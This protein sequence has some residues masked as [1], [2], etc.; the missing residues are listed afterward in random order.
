MRTMMENFAPVH[1][2]IQAQLDI[3]VAG[4]IIKV[5]ISKDYKN[6]TYCYKIYR[7]GLK[8]V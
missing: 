6:Y 7:L 4:I 2:V 5:Y 3:F 8:H 1:P